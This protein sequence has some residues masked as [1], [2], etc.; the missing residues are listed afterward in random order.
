VPLV[1]LLYFFL[2]RYSG[3][4][5][6]QRALL[7]AGDDSVAA[8]GEKFDVMVVL[9]CNLRSNGSCSG[10]LV[11]RLEKAAQCVEAGLVRIVIVTGGVDDGGGAD[12]PAEGDAMADWLRARLNLREGT[13]EDPLPEGSVE[14]EVE[15]AARST[16]QN[17][18][19]T[20]P[21]V[22]KRFGLRILLVTSPYHEYRALETFR[23]QYDLLPGDAAYVVRT[24]PADLA[25]AAQE[26]APD[27]M[28]QRDFWRETL[29]TALYWFLGWLRN[30]V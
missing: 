14:I 10:A 2:T 1:A 13:P 18:A 9:G 29:A 3:A 28:I 22:Q 21:T 20:L 16:F 6:W 8:P 27:R 25:A 24:P 7:A 15:R 30:P 4:T 26:R 12:H 19:L 11:H 17:C 23:R 5:Q